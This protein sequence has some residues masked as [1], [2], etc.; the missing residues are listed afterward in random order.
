MYYIS[1]IN[2]PYYKEIN[3][4]FI[5][6][7]KTGGTV[8]ENDLKRKHKQ[9]L[10]TGN[11]NALLPAPYNEISLQHQTYNTLYKYKENCKIDFKNIKI[12]SFVRNPY[13]RTI[14]DLL[15]Y[16]LITIK[17][18]K[19]DIYEVL[20]NDYFIRTDLDNHNIPQYK[21]VTDDDENLIP[22]IKIFKTEELNEKNMEIQ[23]YIGCKVNVIKKNANK[24]YSKYLNNDSIKLINSVFAKDFKLF[25]YKK[26]YI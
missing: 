20:K 1:I 16:K 23:K 4:L 7:P 8:F 17:S 13:D 10:Y 22:N 19:K 14:S 11:K 18:S 2:M 21:F 3:T 5:H 15:W 12:L 26:I 6:I 25:D 24:D 9:T